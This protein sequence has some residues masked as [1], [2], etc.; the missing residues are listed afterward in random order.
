[1]KL[2]RDNVIK[3]ATVPILWFL[4]ILALLGSLLYI[5]ST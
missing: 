4:F 1:M 3:E 2:L 5:N